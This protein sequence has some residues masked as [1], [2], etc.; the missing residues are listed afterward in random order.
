MTLPLARPF[1]TPVI[2]KNSRNGVRGS[3]QGISIVI[4]RRL[5]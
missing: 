5:I 3:S 2:L 1:C 4:D